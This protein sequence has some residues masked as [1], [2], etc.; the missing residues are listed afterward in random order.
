MPPKKPRTNT[1]TSDESVK[2]GTG[3][4]WKEWFA[5]LDKA[6]AKK[7]A[8][9]DISKHLYEKCKVGPWWCQM[10][11]V[12]YERERG[13]RDMHQ[14]CD[15][16][17]AASGSRTMAVPIAKL[18]SAWVDDGL[19]RKW[20]GADKLEISTKTENKSLRGA[21]D[22]GK[23]RLS[24]NFYPKGPAKT[25]VAVDHIKLASSKE[26]QQMKDHWFAALGRL[27]SLLGA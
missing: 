9:S 7:M 15:G 26:C 14:K 11:A 25:Q 20:I 13:L 12:E 27:Q 18:Y 1:R 17:Y 4:A 5:I 22:G 21:W 10:V 23:S 6:G 16:E 8:H 24:V 3:K 19:R 2:A